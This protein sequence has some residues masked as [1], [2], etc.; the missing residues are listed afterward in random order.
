MELCTRKVHVAGISPA[1][2]GEWMEQIAR[3]LTDCDDGVLKDK[4]FLIHDRDPLYTAKFGSC[5][6]SVGCRPIRLPARSPN[7]NSY[8]ERF[9]RSIK[10]E[11]LNKLILVGESHLRHAVSEYVAHYHAERNH[12]GLG[13]RLIEFP[14]E[15]ESESGPVGCRER[16]GGMLKYYY[17]EAA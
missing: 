3:N 14:L 7:L 4:K 9:I 5:L 2:N 6:R 10:Y 8:V 16:L 12:Q 13:N 1:A 17:R 11:C 15:D